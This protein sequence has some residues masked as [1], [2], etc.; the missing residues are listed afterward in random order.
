MARDHEQGVMVYIPKELHKRMKIKLAKDDR[1][2]K[3]VIIDLV[4]K[5]VDETTMCRSKRV[6]QHN[7]A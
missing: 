3:A 7:A 5:Y 4:E 6:K 2:Q 1:T